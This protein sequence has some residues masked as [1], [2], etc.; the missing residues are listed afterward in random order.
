M[1]KSRLDKLENNEKRK[2]LRKQKL[3]R[4]L[5]SIKLSKNNLQRR[6]KQEKLSLKLR[7]KNRENKSSNKKKKI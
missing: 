3:S 6:E 2:I 7:P 1:K 4:N 5:R